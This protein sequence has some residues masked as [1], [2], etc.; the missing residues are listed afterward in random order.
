M[1][2]FEDLTDELAAQFD[3]GPGA[4]ALV[5]YVLGVLSLQ[6]GEVSTVF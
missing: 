6:N 3:L 5:H 4:E 1:A 2:N